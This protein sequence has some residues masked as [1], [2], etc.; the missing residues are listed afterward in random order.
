VSCI[1]A[2]EQN[3]PLRLPSPV[4]GQ[5]SLYLIRSRGVAV[6]EFFR[7]SALLRLKVRH[8]VVS[9][10]C[11]WQIIKRRMV[12]VYTNTATASCAFANADHWVLYR[13]I[14]SADLRDGRYVGIVADALITPTR[15]ND[16]LGPRRRA[17]AYPQW[18]HSADDLD[19]P[20]SQG[21][22]FR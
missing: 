10:D 11:R 19:I 12:Q 4:L 8:R 17:T 14:F 6:E 5:R 3:V 22:T 15:T 16:P 13:T 9:C 2:R 18:S 20:S 7:Q 21:W 1:L